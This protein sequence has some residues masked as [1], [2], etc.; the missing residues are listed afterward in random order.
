MNSA[1]DLISQC[2]IRVLLHKFALEECLP[3]LIGLGH[4]SNSY[5]Y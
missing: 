2:S 1:K 5:V 4:I 3:R